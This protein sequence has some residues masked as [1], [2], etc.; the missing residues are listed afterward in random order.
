M[1]NEIKT[2]RENVSKAEAAIVEIDEQI[3]VAR[4]MSGQDKQKAKELRD[5]IKELRGELKEL[6]G[7]KG[8]NKEE[9]TKLRD[10]KKEAKAA[11][12]EAKDAVK[13]KKAEIRDLLKTLTESDK[14]TGQ[15]GKNPLKESLKKDRKAANKKK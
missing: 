5:K 12:K 10:A 7:G 11:L 1:S 4:G 9:L 14:A 13:A 15:K 6:T 2:L 3:E 8:A